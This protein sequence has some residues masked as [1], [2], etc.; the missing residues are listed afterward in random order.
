MD[1]PGGDP[2]ATDIV[3]QAVQA[4]EK[5][6]VVS[7]GGVAASG[8]YA[9]SMHADQILVLEKGHIV[10]R[11]THHNLLAQGGVYAH[12]WTLQQEER[13]KEKEILTTEGTENT[14]NEII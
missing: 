13:K 7:Q 6:V 8:G 9:L 5:P 1:S 12:L 11:G 4:A 10:E 3:A 14:K 2:I